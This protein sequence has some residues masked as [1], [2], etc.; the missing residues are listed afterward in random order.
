MIGAICMKNQR[1]SATV[2]A[3]AAMIFIGILIAGLLPMVTNELKI[4]TLNKD[5][6]EA[7]YAAEGGA[8]RAIVGFS[9]SPPDLDWIDDGDAPFIDD[10]N[11]KKYNVTIYLSSDTNTPL[12]SSALSSGKTYIVKSIGTVGKATKTVSVTI[13]VGSSG[14]G[15]DSGSVFGKYT[16]YSKGNMTIDNSPK[17]IGDIGSGG[18]ITVNS[19]SKLIAGTAYTPN[20]PVFNE[21]SWNKNAVAGGYQQPTS[22]DD[23]KVDIPALETLPYNGIGVR[24]PSN[25]WQY[26]NTNASGNYYYNGNVNLGKVNITGTTGQSVTL[27]INGSLDANNATMI[28]GDNVIIY[29]NG[30]I[31]LNNTTII[32]NNITIYATGNINMNGTS[33]IRQASSSGTVKI[34]TQGTFQL[35]NTAAISSESVIINAKKSIDFNSSS[36][37]NKD[38]STA[39]TKIYSSGAIEFTNSFT[40]GGNAGLVE[41]SSNINLNSNQNSL[42]TVFVSGSGSSQ[43]TNSVKLAGFYTNGSLSINSSPTITYNEKKTLIFNALNLSGGDPGGASLITISNWKSL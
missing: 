22:E 31:N 4:G 11:K 20:V 21:W 1:G 27:S 2:F 14:S 37:I 38:S 18:T 40:M 23:L 17:I 9:Q 30:N 29:V 5:M 34:N 12:P 42:N 41:T 13:N 39:I 16:T 26:T 8:K 32:G 15:I 28:T 7:Q 25:S 6:I 24:L 35:T 43:V 10:V 36:S 19:S 3:I 33:S